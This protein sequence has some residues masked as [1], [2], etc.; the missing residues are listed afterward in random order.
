MQLQQHPEFNN[1]LAFIMA[2]LREETPEFRQR[3]GLMLKNNVAEQ[4]D[5]MQPMVRQYVVA[6]ALQTIG[7]PNAFIRQTVGTVSEKMS[8]QHPFSD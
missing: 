4:W 7:D 6:C 8:Y 5:S 3:A 2:Q 1:Y